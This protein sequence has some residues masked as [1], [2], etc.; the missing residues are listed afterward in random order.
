MDCTGFELNPVA[1]YLGTFVGSGNCVL[2]DVK[3]V[4]LSGFDYVWA[5][6]PCQWRSSSRTQGDPSSEYSEDLLEW[7]LKI[8]ERN[9]NIK[10]LW[11]ENVMVQGSTGNEWGLKWNAAQFQRVPV[12]NRNR[13]IGGSYPL[14][15]VFADYKKA[16]EG[17]C[18]CITASEY[19]GCASDKR[20]ASRFYGRRLYL[21]E[22]A[23]HMG[24]EIPTEWSV[25]PEWYEPKK[26]KSKFTGWNEELYTAIGN[27]VPVYMARAFGEAV[28]F[29]NIK[30]PK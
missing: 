2:A 29:G 17:I 28:I 24:F 19:K 23:Y 1:H 16:F 9:K 10:V 18:P 26:G 5:S 3:D 8:Q 12:Q 20:R 15:K 30:N 14:P 27:G 7:S 25:I 4:D 22:C 21:H 11:V 13:I 6:P